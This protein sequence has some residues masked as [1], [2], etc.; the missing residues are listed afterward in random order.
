MLKIRNIVKNGYPVSAAVFQGRDQVVGDRVVVDDEADMHG[1]HCVQ[2]GI[3]QTGGQ[4]M[5]GG[6]LIVHMHGS[7]LTLGA[8]SRLAGHRE[9]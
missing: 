9:G 1:R 6:L 7:A 5:S 3:I 8:R 4:L 2:P